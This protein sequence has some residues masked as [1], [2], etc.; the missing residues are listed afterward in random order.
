[1]S[2]L[3]KEKETYESIWGIPLYEEEGIKPGLMFIDVFTEYASEPGTVLD[4]GCGAGHVGVI[5]KDKGYDVTLVDITPAGL[6]DEAKELPFIEASI[7]SDLYPVAYM[8]YLR[9]K[10]EP[11]TFMD[12][13]DKEWKGTIKDIRFD[14]VYC[15]DV[16]EH[17]PEALTMLAVHQLL[18]VA[19]KGVFLSINFQP[20]VFGAWVGHALHQTVKP[21][22][23]WRDMLSEV[24]EVVEARDLLRTGLFMV[25]PR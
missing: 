16:M 9:T 1:M 3:A 15:C 17:L 13:K 22:T 24:G 14:W 20:D 5:L 10:N 18:S 2:L 23:W 7:W 21:F 12:A 4:A 19:R 25:R 6:T 11:E 8:A